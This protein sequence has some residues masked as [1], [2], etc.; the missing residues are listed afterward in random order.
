MPRPRRPAWPAPATIGV[1]LVAAGAWLAGPS[2]AQE[3]YSFATGQNIAPVYEGWEKNPDGSF[4]LVFGYFNRNWE[5]EIDIPPGPDNA[6]EPGGPDR[7]QPTRFLPRRNRFV[8]RVR[9]P[10]DFGKQ[11]VV[12]TLTSNGRTERAYGTLIPEYFIDHLIIMANNGLGTGLNEKLQANKAPLLS[13][14]GDATRKARVGQ[15]VSLVALASDDGVPP[16][17]AL[18]PSNPGTPSA[19]TVGGASGLRVSW[20]VYRGAG[21][22]TF[23]P[24]QAKVWT[25][26]REGAN[27]PYAPGWKVP[28]PPAD[29]KWTVQAT[30]T[31]PGTYVLRCLAHDG[32]LMTTRDVTVSIAD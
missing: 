10:A 21:P 16:P 12:W 28:A 14:E 30:F 6:L 29:G 26:T 1:L 27:S 15:P 20:F 22:V 3:R 19:I 31:E 7:G 17:R 24:P 2:D 23:D 18:P 32:G 8:F 9:V 5:E 11:E 4:T 25:D 13:I